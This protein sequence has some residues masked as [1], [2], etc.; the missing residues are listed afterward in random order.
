MPRPRSETPIYRRHKS[1]NQAVSTV[2]LANGERRDLYLGPWKSAASKNEHARIVAL[3]TANGGIYPSAANDLSL[4]EALV[5]YTRYVESY[6]VVPDGRSSRSAD[7]IKA[8]LCYLT[9]FF[10]ETNLVEFAP[11]S[12]KAIRNVMIREPIRPQ[13]REISVQR[14]LPVRHDRD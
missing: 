13:E 11:S 8:A 7:N 10:G 1:H 4:D 14:R 3:V 6:Y 5:V 9:R 2:R 12:L